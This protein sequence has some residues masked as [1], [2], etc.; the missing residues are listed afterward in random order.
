[1]AKPSY[2]ELLEANSQL[3][4]LLAERDGDIAKLELRIGE[5]VKL[6]EELQRS[7]KRQAAPF[8]KGKPKDK[9]KRPGRKAG[10]NYG[11]QSTRLPPKKVD[12]II[13]VNCPL[14]CHDCH[15]PVK[16]KGKANQYHIDL[17]EVKPKTT[18][19]IIHYGQCRHCG[20]RVQGRH[21]LQSSDA[22]E[23][24]TVQMGPG[25]V[26]FAAYLNK[27]GGLS[28]AK[29]A[30]VLEEM[31]GLK[32]SRSTLCRALQRLA[33]KA[34]P[35][36]DS[37]VNKIRGSPV[38]YP[39]E[40]GWKLGGRQAWLWV[41]T[42]LKETVYAIARGR[43]FD[44]AASIL[45]EDYSG[46]IGADGWA[47]YRRFKKA[48]MQAC[49][50]HLLRR[51]H[52]ML[53][54]AKRGAVRFPRKVKA[55]LQDALKLRD[56]RDAGEISPHGLRIATG[57]LKA[58]MSRLLSGRIKNPDNLR[59][60]KH[61]K[62]YQDALFLFLARPDVEATNWPSEQAIRP[63]VANR[64]SC[65]GNRTEKGSETQSVLMSIFR[66][67]HQHGQSALGALREMLRDPVPR[68][69]SLPA[70]ASKTR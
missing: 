32:V 55:I 61:L 47:P 35:T 21:P 58:R 65:G 2:T 66:T 37:L 69:H 49:L 59:F 10:K 19:F 41:F 54:T 3:Q 23:V 9:P 64:K 33:K 60:A 5:L 53:K 42:N 14:Y 20:C 7:G 17:P 27:V 46:V 52:D 36:Y 6:V 40:T 63:A 12:E 43:G 62:R 30:A 56:R 68:K 39:D 29:T 44:E 4:R 34:R 28:Y 57:R 16:L 31:V 70:S 18:Q 24:G 25:V 51:S 26:S 13:V 45:G 22:L 8:S 11:T 48:I 67:W 1:M 15:G 50:A 38:V